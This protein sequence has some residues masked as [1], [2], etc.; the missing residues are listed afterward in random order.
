MHPVQNCF[1]NIYSQHVHKDH[2]SI[3]M[4]PKCLQSYYVKKSPQIMFFKFMWIFL[5][6]FQS[7]WII[8][9]SIHYRIIKR[10]TFSSFISF[11]RFVL[12]SGSAHFYS[13]RGIFC[14][15]C[16]KVPVHIVTVH[17]QYSQW[18]IGKG[19]SNMA[20]NTEY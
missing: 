18:K 17:F 19:D 5:S 11:Q 14:L 10:L 3:S 9:F 4:W 12:H 15:H 20:K 1:K 13:P 16:L 7:I 2:A 6:P 8:Q